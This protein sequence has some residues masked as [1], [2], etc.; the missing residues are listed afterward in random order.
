MFSS[1][2]TLASAGNAPV[3]KLPKPSSK[4]PVSN[5]SATVEGPPSGIANTDVLLKTLTKI[6]DRLEIV[7]LQHKELIRYIKVHRKAMLSAVEVATYKCCDDP[8]DTLAHVK[9][10]SEMIT[11]KMPVTDM[12]AEL[13]AIN[14]MTK[15][16]AEYVKKEATGTP[17]Y[18][19]RLFMKNEKSKHHVFLF[20][21]NART[22]FGVFCD[23]LDD[24][25]GVKLKRPRSKR[26]NTTYLDIFR[27]YGIRAEVVEKKIEHLIG[28]YCK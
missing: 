15:P 21:D 10:L 6:S 4:Q 24:F 12:Y 2:S 11:K 17:S 27:E 20:I 22:P 8:L 14:A 9:T 3:L 13:T 7:S 18:H 26:D 28:L 19:L 1:L 23:R 16:L 5:P 25:A